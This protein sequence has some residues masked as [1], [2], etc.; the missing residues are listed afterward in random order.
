MDTQQALTAA[1]DLLA[2]WTKEWATPEGSRL[3]VVLA[4]TDLLQAATALQ[5]KGWGYL[6]ALT[7]VDHGPEAGT[8]E[9][10]YHY[11]EGGAVATLRVPLARKGAVVPSLA[12]L[13]PNASL[14]ERELAEMF[15]ITVTG[16]PDPSHLF[17]PDDWPDGVYP[18][19]KD[20]DPRT[21]VSVKRTAQP[22]TERTDGKFIVPIGPQHPAL[23]EPGHF[24]FTVDGEVITGAAMRLGYVHR[25]IERACEGQNY[26]QNLYLLE[27]ICGICS[28][29]H[30]NAYALAVE[31]LAG[32]EATPRAQAIRELVAGLERIHSHYLWLGVLAHEAGFETLFMYTWRDREQVMDLLEALTGNRVNYSANVLGGVKYDVTPEQAAA[33]KKGLDALDDRARHYLHVVSQDAAWLGRMRNVG[34]MTRAEAEA[35]GVVGPTARASGVTRDV[36]VDAPYGAYTRFPVTVVTDTAGDLAARAIVRVKEIFVSS[37]AIRNILDGL[38]EGDLTVKM[39][40]RLPAGEAIARFEAPR[41]ELFYYVRGNGT[42]SPDRVKVRTPS[43]CNWIYVIKK[44]IGA[45]L[46]DVPLL[47]A[48]IDPCFS[49]NDRAVVIHTSKGDRA[50][51]SWDQLRRRA[52]EHA[53]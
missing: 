9:A 41:G 8:L 5:R 17:L 1:R 11:C 2:P 12:P 16:T 4:A 42:D 34:V 50:V 43:L 3:D 29:S 20:V 6:S 36:R 38:P 51:W 7:G 10:L 15:G 40:R 30:A 48:G 19:L 18:L 33:I 26:V 31:K 35:W 32:V 53:R 21:A 46:A 14:Y 52:S 44:A 22:E 45:Q 23:K 13:F 49:C 24:A 25:G 28:H 37:Q 27:R 47:L 39:P